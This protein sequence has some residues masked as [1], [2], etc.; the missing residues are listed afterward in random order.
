MH[1]RQ[2]LYDWTISSTL[3][4]S[5]T[6]LWPYT[7]YHIII[8]L[9]THHFTIDSRN[10]PNHYIKYHLYFIF[11]DVWSGILKIFVGLVAHAYNS[12]TWEGETGRLSVPDHP[13]LHREL[14]SQI[15][16]TENPKTA[17]TKKTR[18]LATY[19]IKRSPLLPSPY[20]W[21]GSV[22]YSVQ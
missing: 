2:A 8:L 10:F 4:Y 11:R 9:Y 18:F 6:I 22:T 20:I 17:T 15:N 3:A 13:W 1:A 14:L 16:K 5:L 7:L 12:S 21:S 19:L